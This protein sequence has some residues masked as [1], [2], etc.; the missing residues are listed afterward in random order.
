MHGCAVMIYTA[1]CAVM[2][3]S[4]WL[5]RCNLRLMRY[6]LRMMRYAATPR[7]ITKKTTP[8]KGWLFW[9]TRLDS[10]LWRRAPLNN[11]Q[12]FILPLIFTVCELAWQN[13]H[14]RSRLHPR[15]QSLPRYITKKTTPNKGWSFWCTRLDSNQ[16]HQASE[17][18]ALSS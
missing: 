15:I 3:Y 11:Y 14:S 2:I 6:M 17:A 9:C 16:R 4:L 7:Y 1:R 5:M 8:N 10:R 18:C 12:L 13:A